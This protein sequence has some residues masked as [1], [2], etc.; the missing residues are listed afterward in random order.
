MQERVLLQQLP[1]PCLLTVQLVHSW[2]GQAFLVGGLVRDWLLGNRL[3][4]NRRADWDLAVDLRGTGYSIDRLLKEVSHKTGGSYVFYRQFLTGT[5]TLSDLRIDISHTRS[6][7]YPEPA[8]LPRVKPDGIESD[9]LRRDFT[10][11]ALAIAL[12]G[13]RSGAVIDPTAG[14]ADLKCRLVRII[15]PL[16]FIDDPTRIF[17]AIRFAV[18]LNFTI[19]SGT[20]F[21][22]RQAIRDGYLR[23]LTPERVLYELRCICAEE[24]AFKI[25]EALLKEGVLAGY[26]DL[27]GAGHLS[28]ELS[29]LAK[30]GIRGEELFMY[31]LSR[32]P[33][34]SSFPIT[35]AEQQ[36]RLAIRG[37]SPVAER[38]RQARRRSTV[39]RL[40]KAFPLPALN[41]LVALSTGVVK[42]RLRLYLDELIRVQPELTAADLIAAGVKPGPELG[43]MLK[44]LLWARLDRRV[45]S[46]ADEL[47]WLRRVWGGDD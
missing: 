34:D 3:D 39:Y 43:E 37:F 16:S 31:L 8:V 29:R 17:R 38:L 44:K 32:L 46:R 21:L 7:R 35:R 27:S 13:D 6:E 24:S 11:N 5:V 42:R 40:L 33:V 4:F 23:R 2:G 47:V 28:S 45:K 15:H 36:V 20:L 25:L 26:F 10:I 12:N 22:M 30:S 1:E 14:G 41:I 9:L 18:R 19:E